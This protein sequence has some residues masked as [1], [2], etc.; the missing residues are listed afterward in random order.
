MMKVSQLSTL[1][2]YINRAMPWTAPKSLKPDEVYAVTAYLLN[3]ANVVPD[4]FTLSDKNMAETQGKLPNR[5]GMMT[6]HAMWPGKEFGGV[7]KPD[8]QGSNCMANCATEAK[9][10]SLLPEHARNAHGNLA[11]QT[12]GF[13]PSIGADTTKPAANSGA[14]VKKAV[15]AVAKVAEK[16][17]ETVG[18]LKSADVSGILSKNAC[19]A[20]HGIDNKIVGPSFKEIVAK[21][22]N[23]PDAVAYLTGKI[24]SGGSGVYGSMPMPAQSLSDADAKKVAL[25]ISQGAVK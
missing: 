20:C 11:E 17:A 1:W 13:G 7:T 8:T 10:A 6:K 24:K 16:S 9:V 23:K 14:E 21:Q 15:A 3:I 19:S 2:D 22:G 25:W 5:N 4:N 18:P 12:R